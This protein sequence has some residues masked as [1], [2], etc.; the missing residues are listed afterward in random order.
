MKQNHQHS[1]KASSPPAGGERFTLPPDVTFDKRRLDE[2]D[3][4][5]QVICE[6][7]AIPPTR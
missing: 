6:W 1:P 2:Q 7:W 5:C 4:R 3:G